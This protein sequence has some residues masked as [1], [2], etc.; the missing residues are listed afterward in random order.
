MRSTIARLVALALILSACSTA[1]ADTTTSTSVPGPTTTEAP[2]TTITPES[3]TTLSAEGQLSPVNGLPVDDPALVNRRV[4][5]VKID[6]H[7]SANPQSGI[8]SADMVI[9]LRVEGITRYISIWHQSDSD[10]L[11]PMRSGRPTDPTLL[12]AM[13]EPTFAISGAQAWV[14]SR[15]VSKDVNLLGE[16][17]PPS[18]FRVSSRRAPHN[19]Y[20]DTVELRKRADANG[21]PDDPPEGPLW[22]FGPMSEFSDPAS[23]VTID[24][25]G[26][27]VVWNWSEE[28]SL[29]Y[30]TGYGRES[31]FRDED[32]TEGPLGVPVLVALYAEQYTASPPAGVS[33]SSLP[34]SVTTGSGK[35]FVFADSRVTEG[36]WDRASE[37]RWF[38]LRDANGEALLVPP[39]QVWVSLVPAHRG[40][41]IQE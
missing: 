14:Q 26:V 36:T 1:A 27:D 11:G 2:T 7:P 9:E 28:D 31:G 33:G 29:W 40:L 25:S 4:L 18:T 39:G 19:L 5:A 12:R 8:N 22:P 13:N 41:T 10:Y 16:S 20:V 15:I 38:I 21:Y 30:R 17:G 6:N 35:A 34:S 32:G 37:E 24:F 23:Q 3:T